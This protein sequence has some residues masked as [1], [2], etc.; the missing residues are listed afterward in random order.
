MKL[1]FQ[2]NIP[3]S[4][5]EICIFSYYICFVINSFVEVIFLKR[6]HTAYLL[7]RVKDD[8]DDDDVLA[9]KSVSELQ[10]SSPMGWK[11]PEVPALSASISVQEPF[12]PIGTNSFPHETP[13]LPLLLLPPNPKSVSTL[14]SSNWLKERLRICQRRDKG[15]LFF[16]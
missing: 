16:A 5:H 12:P 4:S 1:K 6:K 13:P 2:S 9:V 8:D 7:F 3:S 14:C 15:R 10:K 11:N